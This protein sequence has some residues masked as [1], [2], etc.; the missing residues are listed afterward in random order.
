MILPI[1]TY[2]DE[3]LTQISKDVE[4]NDPTLPEL[5]SNMYETMRE[6][7]LGIAL[8]AIQVGVPKRIFIVENDND[9]EQTFR[10]AFIN[11]KI[12]YTGEHFHEMGEPCLSFPGAILNVKRLIIIRIEWYDENK[13][14]HDEYFHDI[15]ARVI[16]HEMD[17]LNGLLIS[18]KTHKSELKKNKVI[19]EKIKSKKVKTPYKIYKNESV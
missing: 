7:N 5:I 19:L 1:H 3:I 10:G 4:L 8:A 13:R 15:E 6:T 18:D 17:H 9:E 11:P 2:G 16:Q 14:F 12:T